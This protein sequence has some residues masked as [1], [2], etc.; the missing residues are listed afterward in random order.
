MDSV[1]SK[2]LHIQ[3]CSID[4]FIKYVMFGVKEGKSQP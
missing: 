2:A 1:G 4:S 3:I